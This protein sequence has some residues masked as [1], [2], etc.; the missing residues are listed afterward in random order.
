MCFPCKLSFSLA[1]PFLN[2]CQTEHGLP[3]TA[4]EREV[5]TTAGR[6]AILQAVG[7]DQTPLLSV[8]E[9]A[10]GA[11]VGG[12]QFLAASSPP[13]LIDLEKED[14]GSGGGG[15]GGILG[16]PG[17]AGGGGNLL[18]NSLLESMR[19]N[20]GPPSAA[21]G[22]DHPAAFLSVISSLGGGGGGGVLPPTNASQLQGTTIGPCPDHVNGRQPG[23]ECEKCDF[24]LNSF[25]GDS[26]MSGAG[27][28]GW[29]QRHGGGSGG[30]VAGGA[31]FIGRADGGRP[32]ES[33]RSRRRTSPPTNGR[34]VHVHSSCSPPPC[35]P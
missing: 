3:L 20:L 26:A 8:L 23:I 12:K 32:M 11:G 5:V 1:R 28:G 4:Q 18:L 25:R 10:A 9:P 35:E 34:A 30:V 31:L 19:M 24:I 21:M 15:R 14:K 2:H 16:S 17:A 6:S 33:G 7:G 29:G 22:P 13:P 27:G